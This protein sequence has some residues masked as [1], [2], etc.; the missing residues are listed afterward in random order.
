[1]S[2]ESARP[3]RGRHVDAGLP[4]VAQLAPS[5]VGVARSANALS[6]PRNSSI[7]SGSRWRGASSRIA[8][9]SAGG[10][11]PAQRLV[12]PGLDLAGAPQP[13]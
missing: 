7:R 11:R 13:R 2:P 4:A 9:C 5:A 6:T 8:M 12:G 10:E 3:V 1:M